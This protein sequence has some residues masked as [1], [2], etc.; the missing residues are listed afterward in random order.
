MQSKNQQRSFQFTITDE[1]EKVS[2]NTKNR[3]VVL[4]MLSLNLL[5]IYLGKIPQNKH[6]MLLVAIPAFININTCHATMSTN[7]CV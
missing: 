6:I 4:G 7:K 2:D 3:L 1:D 5:L